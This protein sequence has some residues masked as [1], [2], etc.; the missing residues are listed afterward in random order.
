MSV[1]E[2]VTTAPRGVQKL[3][4]A[5]NPELHTFGPSRRTSGSP[6][7]PHDLPTP[8]HALA[9]PPIPQLSEISDASP[10]NLDSQACALTLAQVPLAYEPEL[11]VVLR[12]DRLDACGT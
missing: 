8:K 4:P 6:R 3:D 1:G 10:G 9:R 12:V 2:L 11:K 7:T 5:A